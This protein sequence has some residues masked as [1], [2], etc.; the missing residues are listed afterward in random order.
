VKVGDGAQARAIYEVSHATL[1]EAFD[2][3]STLKMS[4]AKARSPTRWCARSARA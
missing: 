1:R 3:F 2:Y 4:G